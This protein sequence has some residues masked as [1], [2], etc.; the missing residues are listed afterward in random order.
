VSRKIETA[1]HSGF[2]TGVDRAY[3]TALEAAKSGEPVY[4]L[5]LLVHNSLVMNKLE[6]L[7]IKSVASL[8]EIPKGASGSLII[9]SHGVGPGTIEE[10]KRTGLN[11]IDTTCPWVRKAQNTAHKLAGEGY[12]VVIVGD[13]NHTEVK[14]IGEW[15]GESSAVVEE[16]GNLAKI[17]LSEKMGV[18][19]QT[20]QSA[21]NFEAVVGELKNRTSDL[22]VHNTICDATK[23]MQSDA[24]ELAKRSDVMLVIGD[25]K[26][27][28]TKRLKELCE[29]TGTPT[30]QIQDAKELDD[31]WLDG[32]NRIGITAGASTPD[33]VIK[34]VVDRLHE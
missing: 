20:T 2:C 16:K 6:T 3:R 27:A 5:G 17:C 18:V 10:A 23:K 31:G 29:E 24:V 15:A 14:G 1:R 26:S 7:G 33:W 28:N 11:V 4:I 25:K 22:S 8:S 21:E 19:A 34:E 30:Y 32:K 9:S 12:Q 13:K